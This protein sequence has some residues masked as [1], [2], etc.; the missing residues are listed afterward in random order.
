[1][2]VLSSHKY[3]IGIYTVKP[4]FSDLWFSNIPDLM[5]NFCV[6]AKVICMEQYPDLTNEC[7]KWFNNVSGMMIEI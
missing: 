1:M 5:I 4:W 3:N 7:D 6:L 2:L